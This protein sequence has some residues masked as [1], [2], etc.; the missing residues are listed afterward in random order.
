MIFKNLRSN[1]FVQRFGFDIL[2]DDNMKPWL[3][4]KIEGYMDK[5][6]HIKKKSESFLILKS[7]E[8]QF[9]SLMDILI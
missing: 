2:I 3:L 5:T 8:K 6:T 4:E 9:N 7:A 1:I